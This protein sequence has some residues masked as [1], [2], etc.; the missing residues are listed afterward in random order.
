[1][2]LVEA[3]LLIVI[4][5]VTGAIFCSK[6]TRH[7]AMGVTEAVRLGAETPSSSSFAPFRFSPM[8]RL[9]KLP[10]SFGVNPAEIK[11]TLIMKPLR[12]QLKRAYASPSAE[13]G[14]RILVD[15]LWPRG[16]TK[17]K[18]AIDRWLKD[19]APST[20]LRKWFGH[21]PSR[22]EEFCRRYEAELSQK[23]ELLSE[24]RTIARKSPLTLLF[25]A[26]DELHNEAV[27]LR[28]FLMR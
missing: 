11:P 19:V 21:D 14:I 16:L 25:A 8:N 1:M 27:V 18:A 7:G 17:S 10:N 28:D 13:D 6:D 23:S 24:L 2:A 3:A 15:R 20:E 4:A 5:H 12:I 22:W 26:R 9:V